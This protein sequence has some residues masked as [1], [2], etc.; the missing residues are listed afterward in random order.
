MDKRI[1]NLCPE[2]S[3]VQR[4]GRH[5]TGKQGARGSGPK[6]DAPPCSLTE[7]VTAHRNDLS[8]CHRSPL[9]LFVG[10]AATSLVG[11]EGEV[12][13]L[14]EERVLFLFQRRK[15]FGLPTVDGQVLP[16]WSSD[17]VSL[18]LDES[19]N[20]RTRCCLGAW[21]REMWTDKLYPLSQPTPWKRSKTQGEKASSWYWRG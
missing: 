1:L 3:C 2:N 13:G 20:L 7:Q 15:R 19:R 8:T 10:T 16:A 14:L 21:S 6:T 17:F 18:A 12:D 9:P 11:V 5:K 4:D